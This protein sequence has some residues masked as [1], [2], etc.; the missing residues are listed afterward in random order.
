MKA[1]G[2]KTTVSSPTQID[3][4][5]HI[6]LVPLPANQIEANSLIQQYGKCKRVSLLTTAACFIAPRF[7]HY[8]STL[9]MDKGFKPKF[10]FEKGKVAVFGQEVPLPY[11]ITFYADSYVTSPRMTAC[12]DLSDLT[13]VYEGKLVSSNAIISIMADL[14]ATHSFVVNIL[15][16]IS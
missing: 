7:N 9:L 3:F 11:A 12:R 2:L 8:H 16:I 13:H 4:S 6:T 10:T 1:T 15:H 14:G 5:G